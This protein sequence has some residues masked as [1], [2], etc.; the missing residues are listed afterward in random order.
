VTKLE[1]EHTDVTFPEFEKIYLDWK[2]KTDA[3][4]KQFWTSPV[5]KSIDGLEGMI[6]KSRR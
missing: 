6:R 3:G 1:S 4:K 5:A 2:K